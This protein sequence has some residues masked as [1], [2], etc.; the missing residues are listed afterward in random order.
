MPPRARTKKTASVVTSAATSTTPS[1]VPSAIQ[2]RDVSPTPKQ[3]FRL[4]D[5]PS[6]LRVRIYEEVLHV[7]N[8]PIDLD[9]QNYRT[10]HPRLALFL[11]SHR[12]HN[13]ASQI[14]YSQ[15]ILL[16][17][18]HGRFFH[19]KKPLLAR[20]PIH[21]REAITTL[22]WRIGPGWSSP[23]KNQNANETLGLRECV[24]LRVLKLFVEIDP[25]DGIFSGFRGKGAKEDT[26]KWFCVDLLREIFEQVPSLETVE[27]DAFPVIK[28]DSPLV[29]G[30]R[31]C[32]EESGLKLKW[33]PLRG[34]E[35]DT[36]VSGG[37]IGIEAAMASMA[38]RAEMGRVVEVRA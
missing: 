36:L 10:I 17:P 38:L 29:V 31:R 37:H 11:I 13:E 18:F 7:P 22:C 3:P 14:F 32:I 5:L 34:W 25:A 24:N 33:G 12:L 2:S 6:E 21:Y 16:Y 20:L 30:L 1:T 35:D 19:T 28:K 26:Y 15:P 9:P 27:I 23:P 8:P 4:F